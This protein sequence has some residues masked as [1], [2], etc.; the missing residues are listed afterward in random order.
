MKIKKVVNV[1]QTID[2]NKIPSDIKDLLKIEHWS[3][4][5]DKYID[6]GDMDM[7]HLLRTF[8]ILMLDR[9]KLNRILEV[10]NK[11]FS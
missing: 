11:N 3:V 5:L 10:C 2:E 1:L 9:K 6:I 7:Y 4:G 8:N